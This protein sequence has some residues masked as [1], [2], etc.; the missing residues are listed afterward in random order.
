MGSKRFRVGLSFAGEKREFVSQVAELL[1]REFGK[2]KVLYDKFHQAEFSRGDLGIYLGRLYHDECDLVVVVLCAK[3]EEKPWT[4]GTEW[5]AIHALLMQRRDASVMLCRFD[6]ARVDG[7]YE[8]AGFVD[9]DDRTPE[10]AAQLILERLD[11]IDDRE[12]LH[13]PD[14]TPQ[15]T[16]TPNNLPRL[17]S[18]FGREQQLKAI[19]EALDPETRGWGILIVGSRGTGKTSLAIRAAHDARAGLFDKIIFVSVKDRELDDDGIRKLNVFIL[20]VFLEI[21]NEVADELGRPDIGRAPEGQRTRL[22]LQALRPVRTLLILDNLESLTKEDRNQLFGFV[23]RLPE[24]C[25]AILTSLR[26]IGSGPELL[27]LEK[28]DEKAALATLADLEEHI[29]L[30]AKTSE[31]ER[32]TLYQQT[33]GNPLLLRWMA[34][35][36]GRERCRTL[37]DALNSLRSC[38]PENDPLEFIFGDLAEEFTTEETS[39]L[40]ALTYCTVPAKVETVAVLAALEKEPVEMALRGLANRSVVVPDEEE[41]AFALVPMMAEFLRRTQSQMMAETQ[42]RRFTLGLVAP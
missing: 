12:N 24:G 26:R 39:V 21:L 6:Q 38:R 2:G 13:T 35:Q 20:P 25:K 29:P 7:I 36:L 32:V 41:T 33:G 19:R 10:Q 4:G 28:L 14:A 27:I 42:H 17:H 8:N 15:R 23:K 40:C 30:L 31:A 11:Q 16:T 5:R 34:G 18:F 9:F 1:A 3:Y 37:T 22:L